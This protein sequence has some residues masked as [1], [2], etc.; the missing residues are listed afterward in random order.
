MS[1]I[2]S[3][4][5]TV[6]VAKMAARETILNLNFK[7]S[8][9]QIYKCTDTIIQ[10]HEQK[11]RAIVKTN[12][13]S[14][15]SFSELA[16][17][18]ADAI[19]QS[20]QTTLPAL[21][22]T[23]KNAR[24]ASSKSKA[25]LREVFQDVYIRK[26]LFIVLRN[27][28]N[29]I[30]DT[31]DYKNLSNEDKRYME[32][33]LNLF[34]ESGLGNYKACTDTIDEEKLSSYTKIN[35]ECGFAT[36]EYEQN[37][38]E[39]TD[40][41]YLTKE[42]L[43][44]CTGSFIE[45]LKQD[46]KLE[47]YEIS[48]KAPVRIPV[49][50][51]A[52]KPATRKA[53]KKAADRRCVDTNEKLLESILKLRMEKANIL[54]FK[55][56]A[57]FILKQKMI[58]TQE[59]ARK[60][61]MDVFEK[62]KPLL[63]ADI[64]L[65]LSEKKNDANVIDKDD[66]S[67]LKSWDIPYYS[68]IYKEKNFNLDSER[69]REYFPLEH[70]QK[71][72]F[73]IYQDFLSVKFERVIE[74]DNVWHESVEMYEVIDCE[75][76]EVCGHFYLDLFSRDGKF[77]HQCVVPLVPSCNFNDGKVLPAVSILGNM[78]KATEARPSLLRFAEVHTFFHEFGHG[79]YLYFNILSFPKLKKNEIQHQSKKFELTYSYSVLTSTRACA[80]TCTHSNARCVKQDKIY[81]FL[82]DMAY[83]A[84]DWWCRARF[85]G[86]AINVFRKISV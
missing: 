3:S 77:G 63:Q 73:E 58:K 28:Y 46:E 59:N 62:L 31:D 33:T 26:D 10:K 2:I 11:L 21:I 1:S 82:L 72:I 44:G 86:S 65:L 7:F 57:D 37:I 30:V 51:Y 15:E 55:S 25:K 39:N 29:Q 79:M 18:Q 4:R 35:K 54:G 41:I 81:T 70:V 12:S 36:N 60:F 71:A 75:S 49:M 83:D 32:K 42:E 22:S 56:H 17:A 20:S 5:S 78:T 38:N 43:V 85:S 24:E 19:I 9:E 69:I 8:A 47:K 74:N 48:M 76:N 45:S 50:Q 13:A 52:S 64:D 27:S 34:S 66:R 40:S 53:V 14:F 23:D 61:L 80:H 68:R 84:M 16:N 67:S 6:A